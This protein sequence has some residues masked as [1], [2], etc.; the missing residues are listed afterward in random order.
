MRRPF[1]LGAVL[2]P[3]V[4]PAATQAATRYVAPTGS[5]GACSSAAP[6][7]VTT[8]INSA[9]SGDEVVVAPGDYGSE[10]TP[11]TDV[12]SPSSTN[13]DVHGV[14]G[15]PRPRIFTTADYGFSIG[16]SAAGSRISHLE[17]DAVRPASNPSGQV[18]FAIVAATAGSPAPIVV[19]DV[20]VRRIGGSGYA[21][22]VGG[23]G[24]NVVRSSTC[25]SEAVNA[26]ALAAISGLWGPTNAVIRNSTIWAVGGNGLEAQSVATRPISLQ[27]VNSIVHGAGYDIYVA[28][29]GDPASVSATRSA[30]DPAK[31]VVAGGAT[32]PVAASNLATPPQLV[33]PASG[34]LRQ[35]AT[36]PTIDAGLDDAA[37]GLTALG[38]ATL[39]TL[40]ARTDIGADEWQ[41][42][43][44]ATTAAATGVTSTGA[45]L[46]GVAGTGRNAGTARF[47]Y[48]TTTSY[49]ASTPDA[50]ITAGSDDPLPQTAAISG[51][52]PATTYHYRLVVTTPAGTAQSTDGTFTTAAAT[53]PGGGGGTG[54][55]TGGGG[56][57][58]DTPPVAPRLSAVR[59]PATVRVGA[60]ATVRLRLNRAARV[61]VRLVRRSTGVRRNGRCVA[62]K[63]GRRG[64]RCTRTTT[65]RTLSRSLP[66]GA[67]SVALSRTFLGTRAGRYRLVVGATADGLVAPTATRSLRLLPRRR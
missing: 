21:C 27:L 50:A 12:L 18:G 46:A 30:Y 9:S 10:A 39:R 20:V 40:G 36:S 31:V 47:E 28:K 43:P 63:P 66:A 23:V 42:A 1:A 41:P 49:G 55:G 24:G 35:L 5:G 54:G 15:Q 67:S 38:G 53:G 17:V 56:G 32:G 58:G 64:A 16:G 6:C 33:A 51:L 52:S 13:L 3:L 62:P 45:T 25:W 7:A 29:S 2:L 34:D 22:L 44:Q 37:N 59:A 26:P 57:G 11:L 48:G 8:G 60:R 14:A 65:V 4:L 61:T 19:D